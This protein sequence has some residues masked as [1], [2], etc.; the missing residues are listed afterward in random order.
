MN[1]GNLVPFN[2]WT[3][4]LKSESL[5]TNI[6]DAEFRDAPGPQIVPR[7]IL[8]VLPSHSW[9]FHGMSI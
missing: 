7:S 1:I 5:K 6:L 3:L 8:Q 2:T 4:E 9:I